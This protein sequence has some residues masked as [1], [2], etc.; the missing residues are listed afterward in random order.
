VTSGKETA[1]Q[2]KK[3]AGVNLLVFSLINKKRL[4]FCFK[5]CCFLGAGI[6]EKKQKENTS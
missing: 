5:V 1:D 6:Q 3:L 4:A 2:E